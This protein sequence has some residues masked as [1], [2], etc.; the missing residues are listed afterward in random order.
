M[1]KTPQTTDRSGVLTSGILVFNYA[2]PV[3]FL[4]AV[5]H[6]KKNKNARFSL[7][8]WAK[9]IGFSDSTPL[10]Q[11]LRNKRPI[12]ATRL[13]KLTKTLAL[14]EKE[15]AYFEAITKAKY[16]KEP[17]VRD[18]C[19]KRAQK[20][21]SEARFSIGY[22]DDTQY[23]GN[24]LY[25]VLI[26]M[27]ELADFRYDPEWIQKQ[28]FTEVPISEIELIY[29]DLVRRRFL[30]RESNGSLVKTNRHFR[31]KHDVGSLW[32]KKYHENALKTASSAIYQQDLEEREFGSYA[33]SIRKDDLPEMKKLIRNFSQSL[34]AK[35]AYEGN[36]A[37]SVYQFNLN[38]FSQTAVKSGKKQDT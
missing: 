2:D 1:K 13:A 26:E 14:S 28:L 24:P 17:Y 21:F 8:A 36:H 6:E 32:V 37:D 10:A 16:A 25:A 15:S 7:R 31:S 5:F 33:L 30:K 23:L 3:L 29:S 9:Q 11:I 35:F 27:V 20:I 34:I 4:N 18:L 22:F 38:L 19:L 12:P